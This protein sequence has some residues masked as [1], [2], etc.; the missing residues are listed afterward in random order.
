[1]SDIKK[2]I[3]DSISSDLERKAKLWGSLLYFTQVFYKLRTGRDFELSFPDGRE[4]HYISIC[5]ELVNVLEGKVPRLMINVPP[6]Y[7]KTE[8]VIHFVAWALSRFP[9]SNFLYVSYAHL[10]AKKQTQT[11]RQIVQL[12]VF[13]KIFGVSLSDETSA[14]DNF[15]TTALGSV[16]AAGAGGTITG[17]GAGINGCNRFGGC[18][19]IDDIHKPSEVTSDTMRDAINEW[20]FNTLQSRLNSQNTP[21]IFIGQRLHEDDL[22]ANLI[23]SGDW[24]TLIIPAIDV[25][26]NA[27]HP[28]MHNIHQLRKMKE[29]SPYNFA[30]Q[31]QQEP[32]PAGGALFKEDWF[33]LLDIEP[34]ILATFITGDTGE[35]AKTYND[36]TAFC[37]WGLYKISHKGLDIEQYGL[38]LL[39]CIEEWVE[40]KDLEE[41][42]LDFYS[43]CLM[44]KVKPHI[45][46]IEKK[47][48]GTTLLSIL[49]KRQGLTLIDIERNRSSGSKAQ[50]FLS[51][52]PYVSARL[53]TLPSYA[54]HTQKFIKHMSRIT[55]NDTHTHDDLADCAAD[56]IDIAL[57]RRMII[58]Q[59]ETKP[60]DSEV[61]KKLMSKSKNVQRLRSKLYAGS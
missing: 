49:K 24:K 16:Y 37:F 48:T 31:Y 57:I 8:L 58:R 23:K 26:G 34:E 27:L 19:V 9:D 4:S 35:T 32:V 52:Q 53:V 39:N 21:I 11:I 38:H 44:H 56:A 55:A 2:T 15:E 28:K 12:P 20:Y 50:R 47:S 54:N 30:S 13:R 5:R 7:G 41:L 25:A 22:A 61:A 14:K 60:K 18:I 40:P 36:P 33:N 3:D 46:A 59:V 29:Q 43:G 17:R 6:R 51:I 45:V 10:L 42:F 1:M